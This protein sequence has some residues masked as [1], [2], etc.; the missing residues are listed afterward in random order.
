MLR[1]IIGFFMNL[2]PFKSEV[3]QIRTNYDRSISLFFE[4]IQNV[5][6]FNLFSALLFSYM[7]T[8]HTIAF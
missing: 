7:L 6:L 8:I 4:I 3:A 1:N 2:R 5:F